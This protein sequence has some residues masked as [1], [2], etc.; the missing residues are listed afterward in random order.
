ME[1][2]VA[3]DTGAVPTAVSDRPAR[4]VRTTK[5]ARTKTQRAKPVPK[6][7]APACDIYLHPHGCPE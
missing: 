2:D 5:R 1:P 6:K 4:I 3:S 7:P